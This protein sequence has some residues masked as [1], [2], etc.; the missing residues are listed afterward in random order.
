M[1][2]KLLTNLT[3]ELTPRELKQPIAFK[4]EVGISLSHEGN[5]GE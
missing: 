5:L 1:Y 2:F 3:Q 4:E